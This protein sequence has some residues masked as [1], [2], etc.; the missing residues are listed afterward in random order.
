MIDPLGQQF[1]MKF[2]PLNPSFQLPAM[3]MVKRTNLAKYSNIIK[4]KRN[5]YKNKLRIKNKKKLKIQ[6][7]EKEFRE[8]LGTS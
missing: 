8:K 4:I 2:S 1:C 6:K 7:N 3:N 5:I